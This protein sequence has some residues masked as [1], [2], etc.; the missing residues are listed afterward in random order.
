[1]AGWHHWVDPH[2]FEWTPGVGDGQGGLGCCNSWGH[3]ESEMTKRLN[4]TEL[5]VEINKKTAWTLIN[6]KKKSEK[7]DPR[8]VRK[9]LKWREK[10]SQVRVVKKKGKMEKDQDYEIIKPQT[11]WIKKWEFNIY[12]NFHIRKK[13]TRTN[14]MSDQLTRSR[15][16]DLLTLSLKNF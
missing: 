12:F 6:M 16:P 15:T 2:E 1:M 7:H 8:T 5:R 13:E 4:W 14:G 10:K 9:K 3:K 11:Q